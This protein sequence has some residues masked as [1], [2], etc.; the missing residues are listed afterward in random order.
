MA[1]PR[2]NLSEQDFNLLDRQYAKVGDVNR[3]EG[4]F[5]TELKHLATKSDLQAMM[6]KM[7]GAMGVL[8]TVILAIFEFVVK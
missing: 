2:P 8:V 5:N 4:R 3:L 7:I 6:L 1:T